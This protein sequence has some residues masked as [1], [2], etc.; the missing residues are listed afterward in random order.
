MPT[1][2]VQLLLTDVPA[3]SRF[4]MYPAIG[5]D[6]HR[7]R[8]CAVQRQSPIVLGAAFRALDLRHQPA[9]LF[10]VILAKRTDRGVAIAETAD[11]SVSTPE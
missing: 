10:G 4:G 2:A 1:W 3:G 7:D 11:D 6:P 5:I 9:P 8:I